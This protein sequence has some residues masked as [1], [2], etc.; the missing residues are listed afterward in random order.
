[1][2]RRSEKSG[3]STKRAERHVKMCA[4]L[5]KFRN[6]IGEIGDSRAERNERHLEPFLDK[7]WTVLKEMKR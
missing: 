3:L 2:K 4:G 5:E 7:S 1:M 6:G